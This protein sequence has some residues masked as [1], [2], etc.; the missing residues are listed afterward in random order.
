M[1]AGEILI[2]LNVQDPSK[3]VYFL[4]DDKNP[5]NPYHFNYEELRDSNCQIFADEK[6]IDFCKNHVFGSSGTHVV[7][8]VIKKKIKS[9][10]NMFAGCVDIKSVDL[11]KLEASEIVSM[12]FM[13]VGCSNLT[14]VEFGAI[15]TS[16]VAS[17]ANM[18]V[19]CTEL[20]ECD[21]SKLNTDSLVAM[22][23]IFRGCV[24]LQNLK[25]FDT[26]NV[27]DYACPFNSFF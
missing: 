20:T 19:Y 6:E 3:E 10:R 14:K 9:C 24:K 26:S 13:F 12:E 5:S 11:T 27:K 17:M 15:N 16:K 18:F 21:M 2:E 1:P 8:L 23:D 4:G 7:K 25:I 22:R